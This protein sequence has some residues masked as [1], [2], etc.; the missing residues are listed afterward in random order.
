MRGAFKQVQTANKDQHLRSQHGVLLFLS[1]GSGKWCPV[2]WKSGKL[3]RATTASLTSETLAL[4]QGA[5][6]CRHFA[7][8]FL[9]LTGE[10]LG[11]V[12]CYTDNDGLEKTFYSTT[13]ATDLNLRVEM[14]ELRDLFRT[15]VLNKSRYRVAWVDSSNMLADVLTKPGVK[16]T[17]L[18][19]AIDRMA[20]R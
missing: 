20:D 4:K 9:E 17:A 16:Q 2:H 12:T 11:E 8:M 15:T 1:D 19:N 14:A 7:G 5:K 10:S 6:A 13:Q 18:R 3:G